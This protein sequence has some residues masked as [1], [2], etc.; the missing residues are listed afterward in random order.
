MTTQTSPDG[1][2]TNP[3]D[4][5]AGGPPSDAT[6]EQI[7]DWGEVKKIIAQRDELKAH[8]AEIAAQVAA[9]KATPE[10]P[11]PVDDVAALKAEIEALKARNADGDKA[12]H[13]AAAEQHVLAQVTEQN[14]ETVRLMLSGLHASGA[15]DLHAPDSAGTAARALERL[16]QN[17]PGLFTQP[18]NSNPADSTRHGVVPPGTP[19]H[20]YTAEQLAMVDDENF[21][22]LRKSTRTG[23]LAV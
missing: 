9:L 12:T 19:L 4:P 7:R 16:R 11:K 1:Q 17:S 14:R 6:A 18:G 20:E 3:T 10:A 22:K 2:P 13:R 23:K 5:A 21:N 8:I 15:V